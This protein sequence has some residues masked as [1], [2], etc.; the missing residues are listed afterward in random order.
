MT[1]ISLATCYQT[2][3][4][5]FSQNMESSKTISEGN[6]DFQKQDNRRSS[7]LY[8]DS[9]LKQ[10]AVV[11]NFGEGTS[12]LSLSRNSL[13]SHGSVYEWSIGESSFGGSFGHDE[14][15]G[16]VFGGNFRSSATDDVQVVPNFN[17]ILE[18]LHVDMDKKTSQSTSFLT[19]SETSTRARQ[20]QNCDNSVPKRRH[21]ERDELEIYFPCVL[22]PIPV[23][24]LYSTLSDDSTVFKFP[25]TSGEFLVDDKSERT[26]LHQLDSSHTS[27]S[28]TEGRH[29]LESFGNFS[30]F[31]LPY[32]SQVQFETSSNMLTSETCKKQDFSDTHCSA[33]GKNYNS[34]NEEHCSHSSSG[35]WKMAEKQILPPTATSVESTFN[36]QKCLT[37]ICHAEAVDSVQRPI[38]QAPTPALLLEFNATSNSELNLK[39]PPNLTYDADHSSI[40]R[41]SLEE[42]LTNSFYFQ[43][44]ARNLG[45]GNPESECG[46]APSKHSN[47]VVFNR[48]AAT[49]PSEINARLNS[50]PDNFGKRNFKPTT[51]LSCYSNIDKFKSKTTASID[52]PSSPRLTRTCGITKNSCTRTRSAKTER[53]HKIGHDI[54]DFH[55]DMEKQRRTNMK[56]RFENLRLSMPELCDNGKASKI[57][58]LQKAL[59]YIGKLEQE[60]IELEKKKRT[61][62]FRNME[63]LEKLQTITSGKC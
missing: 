24:R 2:H 7:N 50:A 35:P 15:D 59:Q 49:S 33:L 37:S 54:R 26:L 8:G 23:D 16:H 57:V 4:S 62:R 12:S 55:N 31:S 39:F 29:S 60:S 38:P 63:L 27:I 17:D 18:T 11:G 25:A 51:Q 19:E 22:T 40:N 45:F 13:E 52:N 28:T 42:T 21:S 9:I 14:T 20:D 41:V 47:A 56:T 58:I 36:F 61:E 10:N 5:T 1:F 46:K 48:N 3:R 6:F 32:G 44:R 30:V 34:S 43:N 53:S